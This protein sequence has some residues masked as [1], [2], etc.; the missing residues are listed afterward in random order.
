[1]EQRERDMCLRLYG[2]LNIMVAV[3][4]GIVGER[5][6]CSMRSVARR[7]LPWISSL[8]R[9][10]LSNQPSPWAKTSDGPWRLPNHRLD[11]RLSRRLYDAG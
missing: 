4:C 7:N 1:M 10:P 9:A 6:L 11:V 2:Y 3:T 5:R 8:L